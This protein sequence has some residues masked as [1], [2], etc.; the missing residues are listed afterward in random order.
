MTHTNLLLTILIFAISCHSAQ[1]EHSTILQETSRVVRLA[2]LDAAS[3]PI[4]GVNVELSEVAPCEVPPCRS[5]VIWTEKSGAD[6]SVTMS[7]KLIQEAAFVG[8]HGY[9][10]RELKE[11]W[12]SD[13]RRAWVIRL[14]GHVGTECSKPGAPWTIRVADDWRSAQVNSGDMGLMQCDKGKDVFLTC[15]GPQ[16]PDAG[17]TA[18][19]TR[20]GDSI[21]A[22][23]IGETVH[24][25]QEFAQLDCFHL[26]NPETRSRDPKTWTLEY[27]LTGGIAGLN[28]HL[29]L[30]ETG[31][32]DVSA[33]SEPSGNHI[34]AK[35]STEVMAKIADFLKLAQIAGPASPGPM[36]DALYRS[37]ALISG[38]SKYE[39]AAPDNVSKLLEDTMDSVLN[40]TLVGAWW[41]SRW[42]LCKPAAQLTAEQTDTPIE[43]LVFHDDGR[44]SVTL[45]GGGTR[46]YEHPSGK[47]P[48]TSVPD[49]SGR[50]VIQ[51]DRNHIQMN[52]D[53]GIYTPRDF[54][55]DGFFQANGSKL[56][57]K[58]VWLG[59]YRAKQKPDICELTFTRF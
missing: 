20:S 1:P 18:A 48:H 22:R 35:A 19:F 4:A 51:P 5:V 3:N 9:E 29:S 57:L 56:V 38:G 21:S 44:F 26:G 52:F 41:E 40:R 2:L 46:V 16:I 11:A 34:N 59:T 54:S 25:P 50:Y 47:T 55:G 27:S 30:T 24:G 13:D 10:V 37:L 58:G 32:L 49:Y 36:P 33:G 17:F 45:H 14:M 6:G 53:G 12:W 7:R 28:R 23:L 39:L 42:D 43:S 8:T 31:E 15:Q